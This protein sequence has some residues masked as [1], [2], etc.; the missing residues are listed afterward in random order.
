MGLGGR[1]IAG[2]FDPVVESDTLN[3]LGQLVVAIEPAPAFLCGID[4][5]EDHRERRPVREAALGADR[6]V[7]HGGKGALD[8]V[9]GPQVF[10]VFGGEI[11]KRQQ[12]LSILAETFTS[13]STMKPTAMRAATAFRWS[14]KVKSPG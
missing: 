6:A 13:L 4:E 1:R 9:R 12:L 5:L 3:E 11:V 8:R 7:A 2:D 10:P 14:S